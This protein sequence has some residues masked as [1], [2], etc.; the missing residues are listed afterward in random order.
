MPKELVARGGFLLLGSE[1]EPAGL[2][3]GRCVRSATLQRTVTCVDV[4]ASGDAWRS[5]KP[6]RGQYEL[7]GTAY[8]DRGSDGG[9]FALGDTCWATYYTQHAASGQLDRIL[10]QGAVVVTRVSDHQSQGDY[11]TQEIALRSTGT[12]AVG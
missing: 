4:T 7:S 6:I 1:S 8:L 3:D 12:P 5:E 10:F 9:L 11:E 2:F